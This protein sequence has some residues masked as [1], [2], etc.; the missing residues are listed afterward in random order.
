M[1]AA[2]NSI[3]N[4]SDRV[5]V[6]ELNLPEVVCFTAGQFVVLTAKIDGV[7]YQRSYSI[8]NQMAGETNVLELCIALNAMGK[9]T[10]WLF[11]LNKGA[12]IQVSQPQG[13]FILRQDSV[14]EDAI[15]V[16]TGTG[17]AP[18]RS[19]IDSLLKSPGNTQ[20]HL[21]FGNRFFDDI[22][23][24]D[25]W[26]EQMLAQSRFHYYPILSRGWDA[27]DSLNTQKFG[28]GCA[29]GYVHGVYE[30]L[31]HEN[32]KAHVYVCGWE[33]MCKETRIRLKAMGLTRKQ[34]FFEQYDG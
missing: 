29:V 27:L 26:I 11:G 16:C 30:K 17:I 1:I 32:R 25:F 10:P 31:L 3:R 6:F 28:A 12:E 5:K 33:A 15:F 23:Y 13:G 18:F 7:L 34:Y 4:L 19:M 14:V 21:V 9:V 2:I 22:L 8:A 20:I 24:H